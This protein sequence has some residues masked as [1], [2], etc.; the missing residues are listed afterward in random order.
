MWHDSTQRKYSWTVGTTPWCQDGM[1]H[2]DP[3]DGRQ[4]ENGRKTSRN[5]ISDQSED[6]IPASQDWRSKQVEEHGKECSQ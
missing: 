3:K 2:R 4:S 5:R 1:F 6:E